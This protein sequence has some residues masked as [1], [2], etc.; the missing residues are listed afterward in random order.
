MA[1]IWIETEDSQKKQKQK[2]NKGIKK[3]HSEI[4]ISIMHHLINLEKFLEKKCPLK[5]GW[6]KSGKYS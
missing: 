5:Q 3:I 2:K 6:Q 1:I 4:Q